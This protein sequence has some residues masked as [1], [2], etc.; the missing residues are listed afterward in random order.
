MHPNNKYQG[1]Y[2][3]DKLVKLCPEL[4]G[5]LIKNSFNQTETID[6]SNPRSV[7]I[8]NKAL[9][10]QF[11]G[12]KYW[13]IPDNYLC[14]PIPSRSDYIHHLN[15]LVPAKWTEKIFCLDIGTGANCIYPL[16]GHLEYSWHFVGSDIDNAS[17]ESAQKNIDKNFLNEVI[18]LRKQVNRKHFFKDIILSGEKYYFTICNPPFYSSAEE[19]KRNSDRK[20]KNLKLKKR[21]NFGGISNELWCEGGEAIFLSGM[22]EESVNYKS[23]VVWF[24]SLVSKGE[25]LKILLEKLNKVQALKVKV[26]EMT[27]GNKISRILCWSFL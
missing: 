22:I 25:N 23:Q 26:I 18:T 12:L 19:A 14:P 2:Y 3:F 17:L 16:I 21:L 11:Y 13:D 6:F 8:L 10:M 24:T 5:H 4:K 20:N 15:D 27:I 7:K 9:L 1:I